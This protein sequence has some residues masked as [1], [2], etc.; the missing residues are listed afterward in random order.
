MRGSGCRAGRFYDIIFLWNHPQSGQLV[1]SKDTAYLEGFILSEKLREANLQKYLFLKG[2]NLDTIIFLLK[3]GI[4]TTDN[5]K[6][7]TYKTLEI[8][9]REKMH[10]VADGSE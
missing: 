3:N 1:S 2:L 6:S 5:I 4:I 10:F 9:E 7:P 8:W